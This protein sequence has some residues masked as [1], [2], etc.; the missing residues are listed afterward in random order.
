[1]GYL[2][3]RLQGRIQE[4]DKQILSKSGKEILLKTVAQAIFELHDERLCA[5]CGVM[6]RFKKTNVQVLMENRGK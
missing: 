1:M 6:S 5:A 2:K 4:W 3:D